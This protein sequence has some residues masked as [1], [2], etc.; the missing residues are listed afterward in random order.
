MI[1]GVLVRAFR[2]AEA[3]IYLEECTVTEVLW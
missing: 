3:E 2:M 1:S